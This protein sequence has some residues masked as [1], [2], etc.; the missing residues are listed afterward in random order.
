MGVGPYGV[1]MVIGGGRVICTVPLPRRPYREEY[2]TTEERRVER[3]RIARMIADALN[4]SAGKE[5]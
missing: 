2:D 5:E 3:D 4:A 1:R